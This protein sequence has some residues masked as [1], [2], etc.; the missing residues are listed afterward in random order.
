MADDD[1]VLELDEAPVLEPEIKV[2]KS[3]DAPKRVEPAEGVEVLKAQLASESAARQASDARAAGEAR[4]AAAAKNQLQDTNVQLVTSALE[5]IKQSS[6]MLYGDYAEA[7]TAGDFMK[8]AEI[9]GAIAENATKKV[10]LENGLEQMKA[11]PK[12]EAR[13]SSDPV[14]SLAQQLSPQSAAWVRA[15]PEYATDNNK[16][17][18]MLGA[19]NVAVSKGF[20]VDTPEY[21]AA[22]EQ[23][24]GLSLPGEFKPDPEPSPGGAGGP[25]LRD[26][27]PPAAPVGRGNGQGGPATVRLSADERE[28]AAMNG[29][30]DQE[31]AKQKLALQKEGRL[32]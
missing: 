21:F 20:R 30:S 25:P 23:M 31:Y 17:Q 28:I 24:L 19:H 9:Q 13:P 6:Q 16:F 10:T 7:M 29:M 11:Q 26:T 12:V 3:E 5:Q 15:H 18:G 32:N 14:E 22:V 1:I 27:A 2:E 8:A 4:D